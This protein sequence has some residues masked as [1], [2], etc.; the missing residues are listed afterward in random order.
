MSGETAV[1]KATPTDVDPLRTLHRVPLPGYGKPATEPLRRA[2]TP[3]ILLHQLQLPPGRGGPTPRRSA[4]STHAPRRSPL[5]DTSFRCVPRRA[6]Q[7]E[8]RADQRG[9]GRR[10]R[11]VLGPASRANGAEDGR[12]GSWPTTVGPRSPD[13]GG[14][15]PACRRGGPASPTPEPT[16]RLPGRVII[17]AEV[18]GDRRDREAT[19]LHPGRVSRDPLIGQQLLYSAKL[20]LERKLGQGVKSL[21]TGPRFGLLACAHAAVPAAAGGPWPAPAPSVLYPHGQAGSG[22]REAPHHR[23]R[24]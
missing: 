24:F 21:R 9:N 16:N 2:A 17:D 3:E 7:A 4:A 6:P 19:I 12:P 20:N 11:E 22:L 13:S 8:P 18:P 5:E 10:R 15:H 14:T 23:F 1:T